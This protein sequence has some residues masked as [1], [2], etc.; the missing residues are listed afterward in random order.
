MNEQN[1][2]AITMGEEKRGPFVIFRASKEV[3][4]KDTVECG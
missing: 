2:A 4:L 3:P 1:T